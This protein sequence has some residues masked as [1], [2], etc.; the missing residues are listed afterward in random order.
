MTSS[1][2]AKDISVHNSSK[3]FIHF[4]LLG[5]LRNN[6]ILF[7]YKLKLLNKPIHLR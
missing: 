7:S 5:E 3:D 4:I 6:I 2:D 1:Y